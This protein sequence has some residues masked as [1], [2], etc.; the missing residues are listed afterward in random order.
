MTPDVQAAFDA[1]AAAINALNAA[2]QQL[3]DA[4]NAQTQPPPTTSTTGGT[5]GGTTTVPGPTTTTTQPPPPPT[6]TKIDDKSF[7]FTGTWGTGVYAGAY[8]GSD[9]YS[10]TAGNR[11]DVAFTGTQC[12]LY[13]T[14]DT[15]HGDGLVSID[16]GTPATVS[17]KASS[18]QEQVQVFKIT[19]LAQGTHTLGVGVVGNGVVAVDR[20]DVD[21]A[22]APP[23]IVQQPPP[24][25]PPPPPAGAL[26]LLHVN[27]SRLF[28]TGNNLVVL[29]GLGQYIVEPYANWGSDW[30]TTWFMANMD[31]VA[32]EWASR[33]VRCVRVPCRNRTD[34]TYLS[35]LKTVHDTLAAHGI[36]TALCAF[37]SSTFGSYGPT[38]GTAVGNWFVTVWSSLGKPTSLLLNN[39]N[40]PV[41][42]DLVGHCKASIAAVRAAG[43]ANPVLCDTLGWSHNYDG[44]SFKQVWNYDANVVFMC[45]Q[46]CYDGGQFQPPSY[47]NTW[48]STWAQQA[49]AD[50]LACIMGEC[51][52]FNGG[53]GDAGSYT[54]YG[55]PYLKALRTQLQQAIA[56]GEW[57]GA[58]PWMYAWDENSFGQGAWDITQLTNYP[59]GWSPAGNG[60]AP[61]WGTIAFG[62]VGDE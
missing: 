21:G 36:Y 56:N 48:R 32:T 39:W 44:A 20:L 35:Q 38:A 47:A 52:W 25:P 31:K 41:S 13:G 46:Y 51:G 55:E 8:Q 3:Q 29:N 11:M 37:D 58:W 62:I 10:G 18:R 27:G 30:L 23:P 26:P 40:E 45:H 15:H 17:W 61:T 9:R 24:P 53:P 16:G 4:L 2:L 60:V 6:L 14:K 34:A 54:T 7:T 33:K 57:A 19:G 42:G 1:M 50:G 12:I 28:D 59:T 22:L 49:K 43:Y 5:V